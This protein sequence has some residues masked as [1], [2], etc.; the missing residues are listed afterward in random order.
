MKSKNIKYIHLLFWGE[1]NRKD[2]I[3]CLKT[4][5]NQIKEENKTVIHLDLYDSKKKMN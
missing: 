5:E 2:V 3:T 1:F 4:I